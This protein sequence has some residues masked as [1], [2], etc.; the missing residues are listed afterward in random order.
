M[1]ADISNQQQAE[2]LPAHSATEG[3][4]LLGTLCVAAMPATHVADICTFVSYNVY[5]CD[6]AA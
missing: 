1:Q 3:C 2:I 4:H 5:G 6:L